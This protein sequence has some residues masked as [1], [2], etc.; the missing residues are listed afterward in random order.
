MNINQRTRAEIL[1]E[2][3]L[4]EVK[5]TRDQIINA[6]DNGEKLIVDQTT[7]AEDGQPSGTISIEVTP[8]DIISS[9]GDDVTV[10]GTT[11]SGEEITFEN[12]EASLASIK[13][14]IQITADSSGNTKVQ[15]LGNSDLKTASAVLSSVPPGKTTDIVSEEEEPS[16]N[17]EEQEATMAQKQSIQ[18]FKAWALEDPTLAI[19]YDSTKGGEATFTIKID[20]KVDATHVLIDQQGNIKQANHKLK[21][22]DD[23]DLIIKNL[24]SYNED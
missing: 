8:T 15:G 20:G 10:K 11:D 12:Y 6:I 4:K 3:T 5:L 22:K 13:E 23:F 24:K 7:N 18:N 17:K 2:N 14:D 9:N 16:H 1:L 21:S 19:R